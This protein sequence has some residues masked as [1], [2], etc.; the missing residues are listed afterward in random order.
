MQ[1]IILSVIGLLIRV[2]RG[3]LRNTS[4]KEIVMDAEYN[5]DIG[6]ENFIYFLLAIGVLIAIISIIN[7][8]FIAGILTN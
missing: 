8:H 3:D 4:F 7:R 1:R 2:F 6:F 5:K